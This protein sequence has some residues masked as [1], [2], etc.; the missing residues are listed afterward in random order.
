[1]AA[2]IPPRRPLIAPGCGLETEQLTNSF[3]SE[4]ERLQAVCARYER[5]KSQ[6][7]IH[8]HSRWLA[9]YLARQPARDVNLCEPY[10]TV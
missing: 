1:M 2:S 6:V 9:C 8:G 3:Q 10:S 5:E 7:I 4:Y